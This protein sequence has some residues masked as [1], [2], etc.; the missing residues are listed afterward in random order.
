MS[1]IEIYQDDIR[2][3]LGESGGHGAAPVLRESPDRGI[4]LENI[5]C[6]SV[7][8]TRTSSDLGCWHSLASMCPCRAVAQCYLAEGPC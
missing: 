7:S 1:F 4:Y 8:L 6:A 3:L 5:Q 2:D